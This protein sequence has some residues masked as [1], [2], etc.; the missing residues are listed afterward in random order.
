M[1]NTYEH[2]TSPSNPTIKLLKGL[3][4]KKGRTEHGL[5]LSEGA[6]LFQEGLDNHWTPKIVLTSADAAERNHIDVLLS[7]ADELG[8]RVLTTGP[9]I[10][11]AVSRKANPQTLVAA[12]NQ[13]ALSLADLNV[14]SNGRFVA[15][16]NVRDP[17]NLGTIIRTA[18]SAG[19]DGVLLVGECCD[20]YSIECVRATMGS[21]FAVPVVLCSLSAFLD[22]RQEKGATVSAASVNGVQRHDEAAYGDLSVVLM[23]N[24]QSGIPEE[25][26]EIC[27]NLIRIPMRGAADSL[28]L[29]QATG[30]MIYE[31]WRQRGYEGANR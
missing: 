12:F 13:R 24:E 21:I 28:N 14:K 1:S 31:V 20:P 26:E 29:A 2:I 27:D 15:L 25:T 16:Y 4:R 22:W 23:G 17:G 6:R 7:R 8:A 30:I 10:L 3:D 18:D 9:K 19:V 5:F 11:S